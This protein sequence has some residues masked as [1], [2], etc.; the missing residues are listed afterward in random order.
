M[1]EYFLYILTFI[2]ALLLSLYVT[3]IIR[4]AALQYGIIDEPDGKLKQQKTPVAY[5]GGLA[6][7][8][9]FLVSLALTVSFDQEVLGLLLAGTIIVVLGLIDDFGVLSPWVK[10]VGQSIAI[11]VLMRSGIYIQLEFVPWYVSFPL[12]FVWLLGITNAFNLID[13]MDGLSA[14]VAFVCALILFIIGVWNGRIVIAIM[15]ISLAGS[16]L[17][18]LRYNI[19]PA[20]IYLGDTGSMFIGMM[21]GSLAMIGHYTMNNILAC[22]T[23]IV[24]LGVPIF[25]TLFV[26]YI[27]WCRGLHIIDGSPDHFALRLRKWRLS[28][29]QTVI[30]SYVI[31]AVI[32]SSGLLMMQASNDCMVLCIIL[33]LF[34]AALLIA[35]FLKKI[36]MTL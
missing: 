23:P 31:T 25:D 7:Y 24:I 29:K 8:L 12:S 27:R 4:K 17:G 3:P 21:M 36:D 2:L 28:T 35:Y 33:C 14:G 13:V 18:F 15:S 16:L 5:L 10:L 11:L 1:K 19:E 30:A 22:V 9:S 26:M 34:T 6:V 20:K 32:G